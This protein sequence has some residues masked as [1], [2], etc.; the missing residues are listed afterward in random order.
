LASVVCRAAGHHVVVVPDA[1]DAFIMLNIDH[2]DLV[3][4]AIALPMIDGLDLTTLIRAS[5]SAF[6]NVPIIALATRSVR[7]HVEPM[8]E[9]GIDRVVTVPFT[10]SRLH[11]AVHQT[12]A[13]SR[14][15]RKAS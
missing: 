12:L 5:G 6:A 14:W 15:G 4:T 13:S 3:L 11:Q 7:E 10:R 1:L 8:L 2:F 9:M